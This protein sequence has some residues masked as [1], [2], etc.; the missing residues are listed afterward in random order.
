MLRPSAAPRWKSTTRR[1]FVEPGS[2]A[3]YAARARK[4]GSAVVPTTARALLRRNTRRVMAMVEL[5]ASL[6]L[7]GTEDQAGDHGHV[8]RARR[9][10]ELA[11]RDLRVVKAADDRIV[12]L[13]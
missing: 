12:S 4:P 10:V 11:L 6:K 8:G 3:P 1:L 7:R 13:R 2:A 5:L 9:I